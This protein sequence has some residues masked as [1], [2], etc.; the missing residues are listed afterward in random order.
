MKWL[1]YKYLFTSFIFVGIVLGVAFLSDSL[2]ANKKPLITNSNV[3]EKLY[4]A[5]EEEGAVAVV[6]TKENML[7]GK[8]DLTEKKGERTITYAAHN[9]QVAPNGKS[10]WVTANV[11]EV[12]EHEVTK[13]KE[14][15]VPD[16]VIIIDPE[17]DSIS[18]RIA[19]DVD[20]HLR[21]IVVTAN[22]LQ[23]FVTAQESGKVY[24]LNG[25][26]YT[27][28]TV[29]P[30]AKD[31]QPHGLRLSPD[32]ASVYVALLG[33]KGMSVIDTATKK[34]TTI[35]LSGS[36]IQTA[37]IPTTP[38][39]AASLF[40]KKEIAFYRTDTK[41][42]TSVKLPEEAEGPIQL[43]ATPDG[44]YLYVADQGYYLGKPTSD[45]VYVIDV[46]EQ[47]VIAKIQAGTAPHGVVI[48]P[49]GKKAYI[50]NLLSDDIS[51]IDITSDKEIKRIK[52]GKMPN[53]ISLWSHQSG[54]RP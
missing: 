44:R 26:T 45:Y 18:K 7:L 48:D 32:D 20:Q 25:S 13:K 19:I 33:G 42:I 12:E 3:A 9:V 52:V 35:S 17:K 5:L 8:I 46:A 34:T 4:I 31:S 54:G 51:V 29:I 27:V 38:L 15:K 14:E 53:G 1:S 49:F 22:G 16:Q 47:Q 40:D 24:Q 28:D 10:V 21:H 6:D 30:F 43:Y 50:T 41:E 39:I 23:A 36:A 2:A 11:M 37:V